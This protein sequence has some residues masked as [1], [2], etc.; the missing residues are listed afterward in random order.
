MNRSA[1]RN[2]HIDLWRYGTFF[3]NVAPDGEGPMAS[4]EGQG[5]DSIRDRSQTGDR[6]YAGN[7]AAVSVTGRREGRPRV[8]GGV[9]IRARDPGMVIG[10]CGFLPLIWKK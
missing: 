4:A 1:C 9:I 10:G 6:Q 3:I 2:V 7:P 8:A 5:A